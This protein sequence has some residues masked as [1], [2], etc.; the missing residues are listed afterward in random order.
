MVHPDL[1]PRDPSAEVPE[2]NRI[3]DM[4]R[5]VVPHERDPPVPVEDQSCRLAHDVRRRRRFAYVSNDFVVVRLDRSDFEHLSALNFR[6][7]FVGRLPPPPAPAGP[8]VSLKGGRDEGL[9]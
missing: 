7:P 1:Y 6:E 4:Q 9:S 2:S 3:E 5:G 8:L